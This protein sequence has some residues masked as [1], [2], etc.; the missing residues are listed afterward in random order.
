MNPFQT[1]PGPAVLDA[2]KPTTP[3]KVTLKAQSMPMIGMPEQVAYGSPIQATPPAPVGV[4]FMPN[5]AVPATQVGASG[6]QTP[7]GTTQNQFVIPTDNVTT[8]ALASGLTGQDILKRRQ[9][10]EAQAQGLLADATKPS[11]EYTAANERLQNAMVAIRGLTQSFLDGSVAPG[12][13]TIDY[14]SGMYN[15]RAGFAQ[16][17]ADRANA[18]LAVQT[19]IRQGNIDAANAVIGRLEKQI[20]R[21]ERNEQGIAEVLGIAAQYPDVPPEV[22]Q[23]ISAAPDKMSAIKLAG[24]YIQDPK[25]KYELEKARLDNVLAEKAIAREDAVMAQMKQAQAQAVIDKEV[26]AD[27]LRRSEKTALEKL[28]QEYMDIEA[29]KNHRGLAGAVG[30]TSLARAHLSPGAQQAFA[31]S[32]HQLI[33]KETLDTLLELKKAGGT[34][35]SITEKELELLQTA[36]SKIADWEIKDSNNKGTGKW[37]I[38]E[39][40]FKAEI[41]KILGSMNKIRAAGGQVITPDEEDTIDQMT[42]ETFDPSLYY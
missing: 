30:A 14:A 26:A 18:A 25:A 41:D 9:Q 13:A 36:A 35:G 22:L 5:Q 21:A 42:T 28:D 29:I 16:L 2:Q 1:S 6:V 37:A 10:L 20:E 11:A 23:K 39:A 34:L 40:S 33:S 19:A 4:Q 31:G 24:K 12:G 7:T 8:D 15:R 38:D 27:E 32:V 3:E 17:E